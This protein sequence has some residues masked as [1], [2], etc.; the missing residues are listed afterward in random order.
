M[1]KPNKWFSIRTFIAIAC[2]SIILFGCNWRN[3]SNAKENV[4][5]QNNDQSFDPLPWHLT[6]IWWSF[7]NIP[8][9]QR[10]DI[11][12]T[13]TDVSSEYNFYISP[14]NTSINNCMLYAGIQTNTLGERS[15]SDDTRINLGKGGIFSR[16][17]EDQITPIGLDYVDMF[18][19]GACS[20][21]GTE[22]EFCGVRRPFDWTSGTYTFSLI[23]ENTILY[24]N[25]YHTWVAYEITN[26]ETNETKKI[27]RLLFEGESLKLRGEYAAFV[28]VY[29]TETK[30]PPA[31]V[32]FGFPRINGIE[33]PVDNIHA[34]HPYVMPN[35][36][37]VS[38][39]G[40]VITVAV[41]PDN[42]KPGPIS[43][44]P[45]NIFLEYHFDRDH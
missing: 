32:S 42:P 41:D 16:W 22:G 37:T 17:S 39:K 44:E 20:S 12:V 4:I 31:T 38:S 21:S 3:S 43:K 19:D 18:D 15:K 30:I 7:T 33:L 29:G 2:L 28:E 27:G 13:V 9:F 5:P 26:K 8:D 34:Y 24:K 23:K 40:R 25:V 6:N 1:E 14:I 35:V 11:D 10:L 36:T 45:K